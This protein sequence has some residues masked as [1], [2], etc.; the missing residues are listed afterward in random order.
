[1]E[2]KLEPKLGMRAARTPY[3][4]LWVDKVAQVVPNGAQSG[5]KGSKWNQNVTEVAQNMGPKLF[6]REVVCSQ[7]VQEY[8]RDKPKTCDSDALFFRRNSA[9]FCRQRTKIMKMIPGRNI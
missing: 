8:A 9:V 3:V 4:H 5:S 2:A 1:M 6:Q 7:H